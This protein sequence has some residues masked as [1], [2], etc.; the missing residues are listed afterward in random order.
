MLKKII[1]YLLVM[2]SVAIAL[3]SYAYGTEPA[4]HWAYFTSSWRN[5]YV[6]CPVVASG[7][8]SSKCGLV[9]P[10]QKSG[11]DILSYPFGITVSGGYAYIT[12]QSPTPQSY[13][14]CKVN[15]A[16]IEAG[17][18]Q[19]TTPAGVSL[20]G[21]TGVAIN[22]GFAYFA[23]EAMQSQANGSYMQCAVNA[24]GIIANTCSMTTPQGAGALSAPWGVAVY[25]GHAYFVNSYNSSYTQCTVNASGIESNTCNTVIPKGAGALNAPTGI[26]IQNGYVYFSNGHGN[27]YTQ[28]G[29][30]ASGINSNTCNTVIPTGTIALSTPQ[31]IAI[32]GNYIYILNNANSY[33]YC[34]IGASGILLNTC[35]QGSFL[36]PYFGGSVG[37]AFS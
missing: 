27:S 24:S 34:H 5:G 21:I 32:G 25:K 11:A 26:A 4:L 18:C 7:I 22:H 13:T 8:Q 31:A 6:Q 10:K 3:M 15:A 37:L 17:T 16:G 35:K 29:I 30:S 14:Q 9:V 36:V 12:N 2:V 20:T 28:C 1:S 19:T 33:D 23:N